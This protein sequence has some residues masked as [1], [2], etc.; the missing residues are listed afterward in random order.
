[1]AGTFVIPKG[2]LPL[3]RTYERTYGPFAEATMIDQILD[4]FTKDTVVDAVEII[5]STEAGGASSFKLVSISASQGLAAAISASQ[6][7][8]S[9]GVDLTATTDG[10][11]ITPTINTSWNIIPAGGRLGLD[12]TGTATSLDGLIIKVRFSELS[13]R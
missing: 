8:N 3:Q 12:A 6:F 4:L 7:I 11:V 10:V 2:E 9:T 1:M 5:G 13:A